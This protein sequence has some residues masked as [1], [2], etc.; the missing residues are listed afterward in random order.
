MTKGRT[1]TFNTRQA[2]ELAAVL[3]G[4]LSWIAF[5]RRDA[6][7]DLARSLHIDAHYNGG[8]LDAPEPLESFT[9][10]VDA[11]YAILEPEPID[12]DDDGTWPPRPDPHP[13]SDRL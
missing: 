9:A 2:N 11:Y 13:R 6:H 7:D 1:V 3:R 12:A 5:G 4:L 8:P 10:L